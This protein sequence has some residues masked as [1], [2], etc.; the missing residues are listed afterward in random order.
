MALALKSRSPR[1]DVQGF[2]VSA[3]ALEVAQG[4][5]ERCELDVHF[6]VNDAVQ[7]ISPNKPFD[8]VMSNPPYIPDAER[9]RCMHVSQRMSLGWHCLCPITIHWCFTVPS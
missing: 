4:N 2:D 3:E 1:V 7:R 9:V 6:S 5:A 8:M